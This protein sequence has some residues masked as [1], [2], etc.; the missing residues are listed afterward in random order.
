MRRRNGRGDGLSDRLPQLLSD[1]KREGWAQWIRSAADERA[2]LNGCRFD[3]AA[4]DHVVEF[5][6]RFLRHSDAPWTGQ[7]F[8][9]MDWQAD[10]VIRP[11][12]GWMRAD[13]MRRYRMSYV[14]V[15]KKNGKTG[16]VGGVI[17]Y[18]LCADGEYGA[19]VYLAA[20]DRNQAGEMFAASANLVK[21]SPFLNQAVKVIGSTK[22]MYYGAQNSQLVTLSA[23]AYRNEGINAHCV[24]FDELHAQKTPV[25]FD[26]LR[27]ASAARRKPLFFT[28]TTAGYDMNTICGEQ[29]EY[30]EGVNSGTIE[31]D[32]FFGYIRAAK[33]EDDWTKEETWHKA[34]PSL[35][36]TIPIESFRADCLE[37]IQK[38]RKINSFKRYR[39]NIWTQ[40]ETAWLRMDKWNAPE[41]CAPINMAELEGRRCWL[42]LDLSRTTDLSAMVAVFREGDVYTWLSH[43]WIPGDNIVDRE[44]RDKVPYSQW[45]DEGY[46][47]ATDGNVIDY[48]FIE[49]MIVDWCGRFDVQEIVHDRWGARDLAQR[50]MEQG[51]PCVEFGQG[52]QSM[53]GPS[54]KL[55][56]LVLAAK[57][58]HG[59]NPVQRWMADSC[60]IEMD[61]AENIKPSKKKSTKRIDGI[62]AGIMGTARAMMDEGASVYEDRGM[63]FI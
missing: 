54:K 43:F 52:F 35:G 14:E 59:G 2:V 30:A 16:L 27:Y 4:A 44:R 45:V 22:R 3:L 18:M 56:E 41:C 49:A 5:F 39:L 21:Q 23:D 9:L 53:S 20:S 25:F 28:I 19:K 48:R 62:V 10:D 37:A 15:P 33:A 60:A 51:L 46:I 55:E 58:R 32:S 8:N 17:L 38:P 57:I 13:G 42:G 26:A 36:V 12:F 7:P 34:N 24:A 11:L 6:A 1:A 31:D 63:V 61:P 47:T 40:S 29:H 50:L